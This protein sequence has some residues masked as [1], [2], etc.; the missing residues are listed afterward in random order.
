VATVRARF[1][2]DLERLHAEESAAKQ[3]WLD[4]RGRVADLDTAMSSEAGELRTRI[5]AAWRTDLSHA[6]GPLG[7]STKEWGSL[8][9]AVDRSG[10]PEPS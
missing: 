3:Q 10:T 9:S 1:A 6:Q 8:V 2:P 4:A 5:S 7:F